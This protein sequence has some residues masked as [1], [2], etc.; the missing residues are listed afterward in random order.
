MDQ[1][2]KV[3]ELADISGLSVRALHHSDEIGLLRPSGRTPSGHRLYSEADVRR[4]YRICA[5]RD[6]GLALNEIAAIRDDGEGVVD[7]LREHLR[8]VE[9][10]LRDLTL[11]RARLELA[12][13]EDAPAEGGDFI[14]LLRAM[15]L[16]S[17]HIKRRDDRVEAVATSNVSWHDL[18]DQLRRHVVR[19]T[20]TTDGDVI[21]LA[22]IAREKISNFA[23]GDAEV[24]SALA[25]MRKASPALDSAGWDKA[26]LAY[27]D[28]ALDKLEHIGPQAP[29][30]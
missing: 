5:L 25:R 15:A 29:D 14:E 8:H 24:V 22:R 11:L 26:L 30:G 2:W 9:T 23:H 7:M 1:H 28:E 6:L 10:Q 12:C 4:L 3:G 20:P 18:A 13:G 27:L 16:V 17:T 21:L 19:G